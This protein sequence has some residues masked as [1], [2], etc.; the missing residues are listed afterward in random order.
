MLLLESGDWDGREMLA[1]DCEKI[2]AFFFHSLSIEELREEKTFFRTF[3]STAT[4]SLEIA[5]EE[6]PAKKKAKKNTRRSL[7]N[8]RFRK[9]TQKRPKNE[10]NKDWKHPI[11]LT[12]RWNT[13]S[14][15]SAQGNDPV[16]FRNEEEEQVEKRRRR[17]RIDF[18]LK[19]H[20]DP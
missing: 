8:H 5:G 16:P 19:W 14:P 10:R 11:T 20:N 6:R 4:S 17:R 15:S 13:T 12:P 7:S 3:R 2:A 1:T 18:P 9:R